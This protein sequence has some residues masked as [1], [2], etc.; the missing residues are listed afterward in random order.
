M[1]MHV[2]GGLLYAS[3]I[4]EKIE[5]S[6]RNMGYLFYN[7]IRGTYLMV[8]LHCMI[9]GKKLVGVESWLP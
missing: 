3:K 5:F 9:Y 2:S 7:F 8:F 4:I 1:N 6:T